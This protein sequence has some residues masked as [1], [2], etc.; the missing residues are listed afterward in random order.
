[1]SDGESAAALADEGIGIINEKKKF[2]VG[3]WR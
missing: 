2:K 3:E 1:M